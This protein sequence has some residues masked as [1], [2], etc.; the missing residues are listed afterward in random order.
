MGIEMNKAL[1]HRYL[2]E[3]VTRNNPSLLE[4]L[5]AKDLCL[6]GSGE[7]QTLPG[8]GIEEARAQIAAWHNALPDFYLRIDALIAEAEMVVAHWTISGTQ[9][10]PYL[11]APPS[12]RAICYSGVTTFRIAGEQIAEA[13]DF[14]DSG[15]LWQQ[16]GL[17]PQPVKTVK[18][19]EADWL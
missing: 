10:G 2:E 7:G 17:A 13:W 18:G 11:G 16:L 19:G 14:V 1:V 3:A 8:G 15:R 6:H 4:V 12:G 9:H 5:C